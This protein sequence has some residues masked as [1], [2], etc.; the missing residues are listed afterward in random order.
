MKK[1]P[2]S[3]TKVTGFSKIVALLLIL[4]FI[5]SAFYAGIMFQQKYVV[6]LSAITPTPTIAA[7]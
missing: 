7:K 3:L 4:A 5:I 1:L 6:I 2:K